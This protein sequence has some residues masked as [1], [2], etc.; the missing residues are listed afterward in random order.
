MK[1]T[2]TLSF[3]AILVAAITAFFGV[4]AVFAW[5]TGFSFNTSVDFMS[6]V[7]IFANWLHYVRSQHEDI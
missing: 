1:N 7:V 4:S 6:T 3:L 5:L 2:V